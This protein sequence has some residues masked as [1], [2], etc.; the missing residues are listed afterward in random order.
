MRI[1]G[2]ARRITSATRARTARSIGSISGEWNACETSRGLA[3][4]SLGPQPPA[5]TAAT[6]VARPR[7]D[8]VLRPV[9]G[10]DGDAAPRRRRCA[11]ATRSSLANTA[12]I[13]AA[14]GSAC[15]SRP[16]SATSRSPSS[17]EQT[18]GHAGRHVLADAVA[19]H[20]RRLDAPGPPQLGER[21]LQ[22]EQRRLRVGGLVEGRGLDPAPGYSTAQQR[23][24]QARPQQRRRS[25]RGRPRKAGW[26]LVQLPAHARR[27]A[28]PG[29]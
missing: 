11:A 18:P 23:P 13:V 7:D 14:R 17:T 1:R 28:S 21:V 8:H 27:T 3:L 25:A 5:I 22:R 12:A 10:G 9:H 26:R 20:R 29:R 4:D 16:R 2:R 15:I 24:L 19:E 6:A